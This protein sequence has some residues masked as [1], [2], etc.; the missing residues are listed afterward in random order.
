MREKTDDL[1]A[2]G[3]E[4]GGGGGALKILRRRK[5]SFLLK[6]A[7]I[8]VR[9]LGIHGGGGETEETST[10]HYLLFLHVRWFCAPA[11]VS[12]LHN[13]YCSCIILKKN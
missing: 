3:G 12:F 9:K 6:S 5:Q 8:F 1:G 10:L 13:L 4:R 7:E 2:T 11:F